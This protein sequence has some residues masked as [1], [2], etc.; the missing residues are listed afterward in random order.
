MQKNILKETRASVKPASD[1]FVVHGPSACSEGIGSL[2]ALM[3]KQ[4][5]P[6][7]QSKKSTPTSGAKGLIG[8]ADSLIIKVNSQ[9]AERGGTNTDVVKSLIQ[10]ITSHPDGFKGEVVIAD[11][12]Q[13][14][15]G[16]TGKGGWL[17]YPQNNAEDTSQ[18]NQKVADSF[19]KF[20]VSTY[21]WDNLT[22]TRVKEYSDGD[23]TDG[24]V[25]EDCLNVKNG[26]MISYPKF[27]TRFGTLI[28]L[29]K[30]IWN[31]DTQKYDSRHLKLINLPVLKSH[32]IYGV[33]AC[34]KHYMGV[35]SDKLT[36]Q[37]GARSHQLVGV[38]G[39]GTE[40]VGTR[41]PVLNIL[42]GIWV[43]AKPKG[44]PMTPYAA[45]TR[46]DVI[47]AGT[48]PVAIDFWAAKNILMKLAAANGHTDLSTIDPD[49]NQGNSFGA[50]LRLAKDEIS[51][52]G[53]PATLNLEQMN[54][55][56]TEL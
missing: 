53:N 23:L 19:P 54:I 40:M 15:Y 27:T 22:T 4:G 52:A 13:A 36:A 56:V 35:V 41:F 49:F 12:G 37:L 10:A 20:K 18:S 11:N 29:K 28:S 1:I 7:Y 3:G 8:A 51:Q 32:F 44:G 48:D 21:L 25:C 14:Q 50:W 33:T 39:M 2:I 46:A 24:Y 43:N 42:D 6:F 16:T 17:D 47:L 38:G 26:F 45:A 5:L 31:P 9:W 55:F 30:G 34:V